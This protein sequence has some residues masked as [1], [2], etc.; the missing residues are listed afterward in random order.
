MSKMDLPEAFWT[1]VRAEFGGKLNQG[2]VDGINRLVAEG[3]ARGTSIPHLAYILATARWETAHTMQPIKEFGGAAYHNKMYGPEQNPRKARILGNTEPG[4]GARFCGRGYVQITG[5]R[6]YQDWGNR[7]GVDLTGHPDLALKPENAMPII[8]EGMRL[9]TFTGKSLGD[10]TRE[11]GSVHYY[12]ARAIVNGDKAK[13]GTK[14]ANTARAFEKALGHVDLTAP[15]VDYVKEDPPPEDGGKQMNEK[16]AGQ[17]RHVLTAVG[18]V[19]VAMGAMSEDEAGQLVEALMTV[20]G[21][22]S[23]GIGMVWSWVAKR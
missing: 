19:L 23:V 3:M 20:A 9:G 17:I 10:Y 16:G 1:I 22:I 2:Q 8:F 7:L 12:N 5:R 15:P 13:N 11:D 21:F 6:N 14:I 18:G 4:D